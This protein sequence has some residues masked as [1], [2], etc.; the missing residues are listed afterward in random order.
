MRILHINDH[1]RDL[2]GAETYLLDTCSALEEEGHRISII[3]SKGSR[4]NNS[5]IFRRDFC[6]DSCFGKPLRIRDS[7]GFP[8]R[9][10]GQKDPCKCGSYLCADPDKSAHGTVK[11]RRE[12]FV[13]PYF[14]F[15]R[16]WRIYK[17]IIEVEAP[18]VIHLHNT[19]YFVNPAV[20]AKLAR[21]KPAVKHVH[22]VRFICPTGKKVIP[23]TGKICEIAAGPACYFGK[24][25]FPFHRYLLVRSELRASRFLE[26]L[27][28]GSGYIHGELLRNGIPEDKIRILPLFTDRRKT[29]SPINE[30]GMILCAGRCAALKGLP[31]LI[32]ALGRIKD[33]K[34]S[35]AVLVCDEKFHSG[36]HRRTRQ[37]GIEGRITLLG[38]QARS[39]LG[40]LIDQS[41]MVIVP[42]MVPETF[43]LVG[44]EAMAA[45]RPVIAFDSGGIGEWLQ[46]G[47][48]G[49]LVAR[50]DTGKLADAVSRLL[51]D[52]TLAT[53]MGLKGRERVEAKYRKHTHISRLVE[54][55]EEAA[56]RFSSSSSISPR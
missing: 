52:S 46:D 40:R 33:L 20:L 27:I 39:A 13:Q 29:G 34:W 54:V 18:D 22:D 9:G 35:K 2:G 49:L 12:H 3:S 31:Q 25:C 26:F 38:H 53:E 42:S 51:R 32:E 4:K 16:T 48:N 8:K 23:R 43:G 11:D 17:E 36:L 56:D 44:I 55:Y 45:A 10:P 21:M 30:D 28:A 19:Q 15:K 50:G 1:Y 6:S 47:V 7:S 14:P 41:R 24:G 37:A 5:R